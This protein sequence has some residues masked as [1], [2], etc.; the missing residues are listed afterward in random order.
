M[1]VYFSPAY[2]GAGYAFETTRKS[3]WVAD[4]LHVDPIANL[5]LI[6]PQPL[7]WEQLTR[8][9]DPAYA[10]AVQ[11]GSP[12]ELAQSQGF[13][14]DPGL[15]PMVLAS[16]GGTVSAALDA[17]QHGLAGSL[18]S[19]LHHA[20]RDTGRGY[21][22]FNGLVIAAQEALA[23]GA[24][25]VLILDLDAHCG[26][27]T[28]SLIAQSPRIWQLDISVDPYDHYEGNDHV[29]LRLVKDSCVY[30]TEIEHGLADLAR[31]GPRFDVCLYNA[32]M[33]PFEGCAD[34]ALAGITHDILAARERLVFD[35]CR[36]QGIPVAFFLAGGYM[37]DGLD[38]PGLVALH[39]LTLTAAAQTG[40]IRRGA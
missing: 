40:P 30:L 14:W 9:H 1:N 34:G 13:T 38:R 27:G 20:R 10:R 2:A 6:T 23:A 35:W 37:G 24:G 8:V 36:Q 4:A 11:T 31:S 15:W 7:I 28:A 29:W 18:S 26:G 39:R 32:G 33:D 16:N 19:G 25:S 5:Q 21:C 12:R 3:Q 17:L 22:T